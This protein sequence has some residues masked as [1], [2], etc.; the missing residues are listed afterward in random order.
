[1]RWKFLWS[2]W[3]IDPKKSE[4]IAIEAVWS[5]GGGLLTLIVCLQKIIV[6]CTKVGDSRKKKRETIKEEGVEKFLKTNAL[7]FKNAEMRLH[8][9]RPGTTSDEHLQKDIKYKNLS[10]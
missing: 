4:F 7:K 2:V 10:F 1:M 3:G 8:S 5:A 6:V 9:E